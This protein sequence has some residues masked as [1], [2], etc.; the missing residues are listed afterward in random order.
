MRKFYSFFLKHLFVAL[1]ALFF[2]A[3]VPH[4]V[5]AAEDAIIAVVNDEIITLKDLREYLNAVYLQLE[6]EGKGEEEIKKIMADY[7]VNGVHQLIDDKLLVVE[8][9][10]K[11][12]QIRPKLID[13]QIDKIKIRY[14]S[15]KEFM[16]ALTSDGLTVSDLRNRITD[17]MKSKYIVE[18]EVRSKVVVNPQEVTDFYKNHFL[19]FQ[20]PEKIK[21]KSIFIA[22]GS[23]KSKALE[24]ANQ[25]LSKLK[26]GAN[27]T[28]VLKKYSDAP[29]IGLIQK[30]QLLT[31]LEKTIFKLKEGSI[32]ELIETETGFYIF[33][34]EQKIAPEIKTLEDVKEKITSDL[35]QEKF[36]LRL[37]EWLKELRE[38]AYIEIKA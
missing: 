6:S 30:G 22:Y 31:S 21:L 34:V 27:F 7:E 35:F 3:L 38:K 11:E 24:K 12:M 13:D 26:E 37:K 36:R 29:S 25:A 2:L 33:A 19:E 23:D 8:A 16:D 20:S 9:N 14:S 15:E 28:D 32:S 4:P 18:M 17:Q 1:L 10:K 5:R